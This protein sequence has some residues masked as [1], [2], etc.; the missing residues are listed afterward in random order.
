MFSSGGIQVMSSVGVVIAIL[1]IK[2]RGLVKLWREYPIVTM[3]LLMLSSVD[4]SLMF[5]TI[6][7]LMNMECFKAKFNDERMEKV[8]K[9]TLGVSIIT[10][11]LNI[12]YSSIQLFYTSKHTR[13]LQSLANYPINS[14]YS[15]EF[16]VISCIT[17]G[18]VAYLLYTMSP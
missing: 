13:L 1:K 18:V 7:N 8:F 9:F 17:I 5:L 11:L 10:K 16:I 14:N 3:G 12:S 15:N 4:S 6:T 2:D